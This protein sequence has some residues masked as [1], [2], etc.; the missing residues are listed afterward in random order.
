M[1]KTIN[2]EKSEELLLKNKQNSIERFNYYK[3]L[4]EETN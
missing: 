4:S 3:K 1:L 2:K